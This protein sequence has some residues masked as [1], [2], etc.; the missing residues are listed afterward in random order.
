MLDT[1]SATP[2]ELLRASSTRG[3]DH[4]YETV[5]ACKAFWTED[6]VASKQILRAMEATDPNKYEFRNPDW[7]LDVD[8]PFLALLFHVHHCDADFEAGLIK[9]L[10]LHKKYWARDASHERNWHG[11]LALGPLGMAALADIRELPFDVESEYIPPIA[12]PGHAPVVNSAD[13]I[14]ARA[15][16]G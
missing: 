15:K 14:A 1:L 11:F 5:D 4:V 13:A 10:E 6:R 2:T 16:P 8:V 3:A 9:A 7:V 12:G